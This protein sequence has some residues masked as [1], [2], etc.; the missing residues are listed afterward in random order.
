MVRDIVEVIQEDRDAA[1]DLF[2]DTHPDMDPLGEDHM[3]WVRLAR[4]Y[5]DDHA[6][7]QAFARHR[8]LFEQ[9]E[10]SPEA[11]LIDAIAH[12]Q[13][14]DID[15]RDRPPVSLM[16]VSGISREREEVN[17]IADMLRSATTHDA[18]VTVLARLQKY[19]GKHP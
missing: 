15:P 10:D 14:E 12:G 13:D 2:L 18:L 19:A 8:L 6:S 7:V 17:A 4:G 5:L 3:F 16:V 1:A 9:D 11:V